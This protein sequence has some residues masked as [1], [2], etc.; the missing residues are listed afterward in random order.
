MRVIS[1]YLV[2]AIFILWSITCTTCDEDPVANNDEDDS[3][4]VD[5][6][7]FVTSQLLR[8]WSKKPVGCDNILWAIYK[9]PVHAFFLLQVANVLFVIIV[10]SVFCTITALVIRHRL[11]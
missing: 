10:L 9:R 7:S 8:L 3:V 4:V 5:G 6:M 11:F 1:H 2:I